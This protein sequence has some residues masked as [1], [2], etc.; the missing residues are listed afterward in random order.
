[1][2]VLYLLIIGAAAG[3]I[4]T[5]I[6]DLDTNVPATI[7]IGVLGAVSVASAA[8]YQDSAIHDLA[9][10]PDGMVKDIKIEHPSGKFDVQLSLK[11]KDDETQDGDIQ[12]ERAGLL[13]TTRML[14]RGEAYVPSSVWDGKKS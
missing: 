1:M 11:I 7:A 2:A 14:A 9:T 10:L 8:L 12:I 13:R 4:A 3:F 6:M 5:R